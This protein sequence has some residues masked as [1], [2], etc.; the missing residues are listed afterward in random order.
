MGHM[1]TLSYDVAHRTTP[2]D[3]ATRTAEL[4]EALAAEKPHLF[5]AINWADD[6]HHATLKGK[7]FEAAFTVDASHVR[8]T[9]RLGLLARAFKGKVESALRS[10]LD[11][12]FPKD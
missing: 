8:V 1:A 4:M 7:G 10:R 11:T 9:I 5:Q 12:E 3:A 2:S 6:G